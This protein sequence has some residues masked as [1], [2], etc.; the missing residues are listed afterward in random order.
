MQARIKAGDSFG[1][2]ADEMSDL[3]SKEGGGDVGWID[4]KDLGEEE[5]AETI[6]KLAIGETSQPIRTRRGWEIFKVVER[7]TGKTKPLADCRSD[8]V[9]LI[10]TQYR[11]AATQTRSD[12]L[13][14]RYNASL[15]LDAFLAALAAVRPAPQ[16]A[17]ASSG[18][19]GGGN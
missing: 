2:I 1:T 16:P 11:K 3:P 5:G 19:A 13:A 12:E 7:E 14:R 9:N 6:R 17:D 18:T 10:N 4:E 8:I 15:N